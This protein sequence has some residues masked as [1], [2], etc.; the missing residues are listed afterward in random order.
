MQEDDFKPTI[1]I[2]GLGLM[3]GS[4]A[5]ALGPAGIAEHI[6]GVEPDPGTLSAAIARGAI[7]EG[8]ETP[9]TYLA[10]ADIIVL[11]T[12]VRTILRLLPT[13]GNLARHGALILDLGSSKAEIVRAMDTLPPS[14]HA[15][16]GH[17]MCG[18][19]TSGF[20]VADGGLYRNRLV[21]LTPT[22]R[23]RDE[24]MT[25][26]TRL[27]TAIGARAMQ[28]EATRHDA[29]VAATSHVPYLVAA[30][31]IL[32]ARGWGAEDAAVW[33]LA[34][35]GFYDTTRLAASDTTMMLDILLTNGA[36]IS[37]RLSDYAQGL[38]QLADLVSH[39]DE[40]DLTTWINCAAQARRA[41]AGGTRHD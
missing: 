36:A 31:L 29:L 26:A 8:H 7:A 37:A 39:G 14:I 27:I 16:G 2:I 6:I 34:A 38:A 11:A 25:S 19:E 21:I 3:G 17:P 28:M 30:N 32:T 15:V 20:G 41:M 33:E 1:A 40:S 4:L 9:G 13:V 18:K 22:T 24:D 10:Q 12:P 5:L 35:S 23:T